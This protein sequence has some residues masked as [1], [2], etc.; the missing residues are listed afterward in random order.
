MSRDKASVKQSED[1]A[2]DHAANLPLDALP[3]LHDTLVGAD[4]NALSDAPHA[5]D[6]LS[7]SSS[8]N[9]AQLLRVQP[10]ALSGL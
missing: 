10:Y 2:Q 7:V 3:G 5:P 8:Y 6:E 1:P 4:E 9:K